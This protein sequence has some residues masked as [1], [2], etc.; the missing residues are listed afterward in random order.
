MTGL[1]SNPGIQLNTKAYS[2]FDGLATLRPETN[3][4]LGQNQPWM[5]LN[6]AFVDSVGQ[7]TLDRGAELLVSTD[8]VQHLNFYSSTGVV[9]AVLKGSGRIALTSDTGISSNEIFTQFGSISSVVFSRRVIFFQKALPPWE[10]DGTAYNPALSASMRAL[11]PAFATTSSRRLCV[12]GVPSSPTRVFLSRVDT[13]TTFIDDEADAETSVLRAG[14]IDVANLLTSVDE[15]SGLAPFEQ[16]R[17]CIF[18]KDRTFIFKIDPD[19]T[20]W[21]IEDRTNVN[22]GCIS[23][24]TIR[25]AGDDVL[26]CSRNGVHSVRRSRQNGIIVE[27]VT[28]SEPVKNLYRSLVRSMNDPSLI[29]AVYDRDEAQYHIFFPQAGSNFTKRLTVTIPSDEKGT[30]FSTGDFLQAR[31]GAFLGGNLIFG[32]PAGIFNVAPV[33]VS[34]TYEPTATAITPMLWLGDI[35]NNKRTHSMIVQASGQ[36]TIDLEIFDENGLPLTTMS[37]EIDG[38]LDDNS[39]DGVP[40]IKQYERPF[41]YVVRGVRIKFTINGNGLVR[42]SGFAVRTRKEI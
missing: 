16:N 25:P 20:A 33:S 39:Y 13:A 22:V 27:S 36:G 11:G 10:F 37:M 30:K 18:T 34:A 12:A 35:S 1:R 26:F 8:P 29:S 9:A 21:S 23:H 38:T 15:I 4:D 3:A 19:I 31:C 6:N 42:L 28:L 17:L 2:P 41:E 32:S 14:Y 5:T 40:I 7:V 24:N